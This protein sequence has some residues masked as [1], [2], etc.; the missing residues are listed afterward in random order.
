VQSRANRS[1]H[2]NVAVS[3]H[4]DALVDERS[5]D[6]EVAGAGGSTASIEATAVANARSV[7]VTRAL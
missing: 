1:E 5:I 6:H 4:P 2:V 3:R 7:S